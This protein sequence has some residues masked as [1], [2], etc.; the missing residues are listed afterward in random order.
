MILF[1]R[2]RH[3]HGTYAIL[4]LLVLGVLYGFS[5]SLDFTPKEPPVYGVTFSKQHAQHLG[6]DWQET[7]L[8]LVDD[9]GVRQFRI[10]AYWND[11]EW[12]DNSFHFDELDWQIKHIRERGGSV[13][14]AVGR[15]LPRWP[16]CHVPEWARGLPEEVQQ[17]QVLDMIPHVINRYKNDPTITQWQVE[18]EPLLPFFGECPKSDVAFLKKEI[19]AVRELDNRPI[20][21]TASGEF[22]DWSES[23]LLGDVLGVSLYR[24]VWKPVLNHISYPLSP[25]VYALRQSFTRGQGVQNII[26]SELQLESWSPNSQSTEPLQEQFRSMNPKLF[27]ENIAFAR[28]SGFHE[29]YLWGAEWWYWLKKQNHPEMWEIARTLWHP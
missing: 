17:Q 27:K 23:G 11:L 29:M 8:A 5:F 14:L 4:L 7:F 9:L 12:P 28:R 6:L 20:M 19:A 10:A 13:I 2:P 16:E 24:I 3:R 1:T 15:R 21:I 26:L 25:A 18:N 22:G